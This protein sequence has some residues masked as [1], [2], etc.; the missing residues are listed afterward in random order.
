MHSNFITPPD[1]VETVLI[2]NAV[3]E[4]IKVLATLIQTRDKTYNVYFY[5]E[6]MNNPEW[7]EKMLEKADTVLD[8]KL[9]NLE[10]YFNK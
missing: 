4:Q 6:E 7:V 1:Y 9:N 5:R 2:L 8:A 3:E 10:D